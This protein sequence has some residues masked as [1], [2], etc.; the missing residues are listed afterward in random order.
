MDKI[1]LSHTAWK[2]QYHIVFIPKYRKN[3]GES[4]GLHISHASAPESILEF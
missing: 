2:Y 4:S 3:P 1:I